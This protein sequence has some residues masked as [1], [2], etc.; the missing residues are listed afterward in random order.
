ML[1][2][3]LLANRLQDLRRE[4]AWK[5]F[6]IPGGFHAT[7]D[8]QSVRD[9]VFEII[10]SSG[11]RIDA[12]ILDKP[13]ARPKFWQDEL[14][15]YELAW[16]Y[17]MKNVLPQVADIDDQLLVVAASI[18]TKRKRRSFQQAISNVITQVAP[19]RQLQCVV[20]SAVSDMCLQVS[21]Y[22]AWGIQRKWESGDCRSYDLIKSNINREFDLFAGGNVKYY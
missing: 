14:A 19:E 7:D 11:L 20:W 10:R 9:A 22:C 5:S 2:G 21:D 6:E 1:Q 13:K 3:H 4:L 12:T 17:H 16:F 18:G 8:K 15:F